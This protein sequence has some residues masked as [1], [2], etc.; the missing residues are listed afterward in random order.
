MSKR[1]ANTYLTHDNWDNEE[2]EESEEVCHYQSFEILQF[3][4]FFYHGLKRKKVDSNVVFVLRFLVY[5]EHLLKCSYL[6]HQTH[7][8]Q[9][10]KLKIKKL[11]FNF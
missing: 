6:S 10:N 8:I 7:F 11:K 9:R 1:G 3:F 4:Q 5:C 2:E